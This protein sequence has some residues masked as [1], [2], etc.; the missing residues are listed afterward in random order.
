VETAYANKHKYNKINQEIR[1]FVVRETLWADISCYESR[2]SD[3][4]IC[5]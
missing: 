5:I 1:T 3:Y 4:G 2:F